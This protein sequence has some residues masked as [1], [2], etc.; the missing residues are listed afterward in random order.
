MS[1]AIIDTPN[2]SSCNG[3]IPATLSYG[4]DRAA[5]SVRPDGC[6]G[7]AGL[8]RTMGGGIMFLVREVLVLSARDRRGGRLT[9]SSYE[10]KHEAHSDA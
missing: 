4:F 3:E 9:P 8:K 6:A 7:E 10:K 5:S 2:V 1:D